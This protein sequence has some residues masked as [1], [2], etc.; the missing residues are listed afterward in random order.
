[1]S[2]S[3][4]GKLTRC[5]IAA[6]VVR[7]DSIGTVFIGE[8]I[9]DQYAANLNGDIGLGVLLDSASNLRSDKEPKVGPKFRGELLGR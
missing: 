2:E 4:L 7:D 8:P 5:V 9:A 6:N 3:N 1:M